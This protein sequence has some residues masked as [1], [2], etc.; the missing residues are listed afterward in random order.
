MLRPYRV[1]TKTT[2]ISPEQLFHRHWKS[3]VWAHFIQL[4]FNGKIISREKLEALTG[5]ERHRQQ[6]WESHNP[7]IKNS[8][9]FVATDVHLKNLKGF[10]EEVNPTAFQFKNNQKKP[11][12][13][14]V[15]YRMPDRRRVEGFI[16]E[17]GRGQSKKIN[18][19]LA[20][21]ACA[22]NDRG[23]IVGGIRQR[24]FCETL[25]QAEKFS[26]RFPDQIHLYREY[27]VDSGAYLW[28][29][30]VYQKPEVLRTVVVSNAVEVEDVGY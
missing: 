20:S 23:P 8:Y 14:Y 28:R 11:K 25:E 24:I 29:E 10:R 19:L 12:Q 5:I 18:V 26:R 7:A 9:N 17:C 3:F 13:E 4:N 6:A 15:A 16:L 1:D 22:C 2:K 21:T 30:Y 27:A